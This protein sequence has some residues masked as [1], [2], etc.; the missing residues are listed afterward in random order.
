[1]EDLSLVFPL[2]ISAFQKNKSL[3]KNTAKQTSTML[4]K[5]TT[6]QLV[7]VVYLFLIS[8]STVLDPFGHHSEMAEEVN[9]VKSRGL[10]SSQFW[11]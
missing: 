10:L 8:I 5:L 1:M 9:F 4:L 3:E 11:R 7:K 6:E 2:C